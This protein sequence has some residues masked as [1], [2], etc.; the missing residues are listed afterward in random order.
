MFQELVQKYKSKSY[1][2]EFLKKYEDIGEA[3]SDYLKELYDNLKNID[4]KE[5]E[6][7][8]DGKN[9]I[10]LLKKLRMAI[11]KNDRLH[12]ENYSQLLKSV[13]SAELYSDNLRFI[14]E[15][16]QN[17]DDCEY[18]KPEFCCLDMK[19]DFNKEQVILTYNEKGFTPSNVFAITGI[20]ETAKN[21]SSTKNEIG[22]KGIGFKSVFGIAE[23][24]WIKSGFFSF[25][26]YKNDFTV[27]QY[28]PANHFKGTQMI[29]YVPHKTQQ[30]YREIKEQ[31]CKK[32]ALFTKNPILFLNKLTSL[33][34]Y[35]DVW[36]SMEF[37]ISRSEVS[38]DEKKINIERNIKISVKLND[39]DNKTWM[40]TKE[41]H[42]IYCT[43]YSYP[44]VFSKKAC[45]S[46][47]G[48]NTPV[49]DPNGKN[50]ILRVIFP[51]PEN[52]SDVGKG[53]L[54]SFL[55]TQLKLTVPIVFH[56]PFKLDASREFVDPQDENLWFQEAS[57]YL[58]ELLDYA[59]MDWR[60]IVKEK[61]VYYIPS[62]NNSLFADNNGKEK[63]LRKQEYFLGSHY[64]KLPLFYTA[65]KTFHKA[66]EIFCFDMKEN[67]TEQEKV[68]DWLE[69]KKSLFISSIS[70]EKFGFTIE[71]NIKNRLFI[72]ALSDN[73]FT[74]QI[75]DYLDSVNYIYSDNAMQG[76]TFSFTSEQIEVI[77]KHNKLSDMLRSLECNSIKSNKIFKIKVSDISPQLLSDVLGNNFELSE[78]PKQVEKYM[79]FCNEKCACLDIEKNSYLPC[80]N[81][82][83]LSKKS[84]M[85]SFT[86]FCH[87]ID[88]KDLF[89]TRMRLREASENLNKYETDTS[90]TSS[91]YMHN[92]QNIRKTIKESLGNKG[93]K[94]YIDLILRAG[95][96]NKE[97][98]IHELLQN[99]DDCEYPPDVTPT[100]TL[101]YEKGK[102]ITQY[103]ETGFD[104]HNIRSI[105]AIGES[106]KNKIINGQVS[107][108][109]EK[110]IGFKTIFA[111]ISEVKI[112][113]GEF[114]FSLTHDE[115]TIPKSL[116][117]SDKST[118]SGTKME[119]SIKDKA[120]LSS[121]D[122]KTILEL[123]L[124]LRKLKKLH[125]CSHDVTIE[126]TDTHR[127]ITIGNKQYSFKRF[128]H[129]FT[130]KDKDALEQRKNGNDK[131]SQQQQI[132]CFVPE[133]NVF[134]EYY[135]YTGMPT[136]HKIKIPLVIDAPFALTTSRE[137]IE[138]SF[139]AWNDI[140]RKELYSALID[141]MIVLKNT[142][143]AKIFRFTRFITQFAGYRK[144]EYVNEISDCSY[145]N[146]NGFLN[147]LKSCPI[148]PTFNEIVFSVPKYKNTY[149]YPDF[150]HILLRILKTSGLGYGNIDT[151]KIADVPNSEKFRSTL[152]ALG[153]EIA[154][155]EKVYP[156]I[157]EYAAKYIS[158]SEF[159]KKFYEYLDDKDTYIPNTYKE[160]LRQLAIIPVYN[161]SG[162]VKYISWENDSIFV[163]RG[164]TK[165]GE[166][167]YILKEDLLSKS[168]CEKIFNVCI[169]EMNEE[170]EHSRYN[171]RL[172][173]LL[174]STDMKHIYRTLLYEY[175]SG[176]LR[177]NDSFRTLF[178]LKT[179][180]P[181]K[182]Q[183]GEIS[184][185]KMFICNQP[186][187]YFSVKMLQRMIINKECEGLARYIECG[188]LKDIHYEEIDYSEKLTAD[189]IEQ[190]S[191]SDSYFINSEEILRGFYRDG[192]ISG[193]LLSENLEYLKFCSPNAYDE[194]YAFPSEP[195]IN[196]N[197]LLSHVRKSYGYKRKI[198]SVKVERTV[199][200]GQNPD[201]STFELTNEDTRIGA[202][203][204]YAPEGKTNYCFC[205]ICKKLMPTQLIEVNNLELEPEY[206]SP[207]LRVALCLNCSKYFKSLRASDYKRKAYIE[208]IK[209][210]DIQNQGN[211]AISI[212]TDKAITFTAT[213]L[214]EIQEILKLKQS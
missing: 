119:M 68:R 97:R 178:A 163:K 173:K 79:R 36:R 74:S 30:I 67:L 153:C 206:Y 94:N 137:A 90:I 180:I 109:G 118:F 89:V 32:E 159:R 195:V 145:L 49:G 10:E 105:T 104:R 187:G 106:T 152:N 144:Q 62:L 116:N 93:Y 128:T 24:V 41:N 181:L 15:L 66:N 80:L 134:Q 33:K 166:D 150:V 76:K 148:L 188:E 127:M 14:F 103:N 47:Y 52:L 139:S 135:L 25:E 70:A 39:Y 122:E 162:D 88:P 168:L 53:A 136:K 115:P 54:Y 75:L 22:E 21:I 99:A 56:V 50:M 123:C 189:D 147:E 143:R 42:E 114:A 26:L 57:R 8:E 131:I 107:P 154:N 155:F 4:N 149:R 194:N 1:Y 120:S 132:I 212:D 183:L 204:R 138:T 203:N 60:D 190:I 65:D 27:P 77:F 126:D 176:A 165:S 71:S 3:Y 23:K 20:A 5:I 117:T 51:S 182:N 81:V 151:Y 9:Y 64:L 111:V 37:N 197:Q 140:I 209:K 63:C 86:E 186:V 121:Y 184:N 160:Q 108:I 58:S 142:E 6:S 174:N 157:T 112:F 35:Y 11:A 170:Y 210:T 113:S 205:Q 196:R 91:D 95:T 161:K 69:L 96:D 28:R 193:E 31:Y 29:L 156:I 13:L 169:N 100:F 179:K 214:A 110:G 43:R 48:N 84:P 78:T 101:S 171:K 213:H 129:K 40:E 172:E 44:V 19:F 82:L 17:V 164:T 92:L 34:I 130:I 59:Y 201:G 133:K 141:I 175:S 102:I 16:I 191:D 7:V 12:G 124:C 167:Y 192:L 46:R 83:I 146:W 87:S 85:D 207:Q 200:K 198:I 211:I 125:I 199:K 18:E 177:K 208:K 38:Y 185:T 202:M 45:Q 158:E 73:K 61:I 72:K 55:P 2:N 98:F